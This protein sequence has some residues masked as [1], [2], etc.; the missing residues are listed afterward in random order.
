MSSMETGDGSTSDG[1]CF[2]YCHFYL[3][4]L[5]HR[6]CEKPL[7]IALHL[8]SETLAEFDIAFIAW[9]GVFLLAEKWGNWG[10]WLQWLGCMH[11]L[12]GIIEPLHLRMD[13]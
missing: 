11:E 1:Y 12:Q 7:V 10:I 5:A 3:T 2:H 13:F 4:A 6:L 9:A 8:G